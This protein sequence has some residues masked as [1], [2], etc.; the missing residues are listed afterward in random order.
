MM[1]L[2]AIF[3][4]YIIHHGPIC[5]LSVLI[6]V[7]SHGPAGLATDWNQMVT[8]VSSFATCGELTHDGT[9]MNNEQRNVIHTHHKEESQA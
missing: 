7:C 2:F 3:Q 9:K 8:W 4:A 6:C 5:S 1:P